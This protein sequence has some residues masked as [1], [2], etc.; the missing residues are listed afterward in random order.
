MNTIFH[1]VCSIYV[2]GYR[3]EVSCWQLRRKGATL[4]L[5]GRAMELGHPFH[6]TLTR[7]PGGNARHLKSRDPFV[8]AAQQLISSSNNNRSA[9]IWADRRWN[10]EW[11]QST[12]SL[13]TFIPDIGTPTPGMSCQKQ[14]GPGLAASAP[15]SNVSAPAYTNRVWPLLWFVR[16]VQRNR[17]FAM[18]SCPVHRPP[19]GAHGLA[20]STLQLDGCSTPAI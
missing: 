16:L 11:L 7:W 18:L 2:L 12:T 15:V 10:A 19:H 9:V 1:A 4:S 8:P 6:S 5:A 3:C 20:V 13:R 17:P 14:R